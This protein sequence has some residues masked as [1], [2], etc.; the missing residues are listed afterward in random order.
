M[1]MR[2][3]AYL[4]V[5]RGV[6]PTTAA[7][8]ISTVQGWHA[9]RFGCRLAGGMQLGRVKALIKG[10][11]AAQGGVRPKKKRLGFKPRQLAQLMAELLGG[12]TALEANWRACFSVGFCGLLRGAELGLATGEAWAA[13]TCVTRADVSFRGKGG[14][15][16]AVLMTRPRKKGVHR[17]EQ[18]K[19]VPVLLTGGGKFLDPVR[20]LKELFARDPVPERLW[21]ST[22]LFRGSDGA[23][24]STAKVRGMVRTMVALGGVDPAL[25]GAHSLRIGGATA[26]LAAGVSALVIKAMGRWGSDVYEIYAHLSDVASRDFGGKVA[27]VD[28]EEVLG[29]YYS[30][31]L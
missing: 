13:D 2:F 28:Y 21:A 23:A 26:A 17:T 7:S 10:M 19:R 14:R 15:E 6:Q 29:A 8:Y 12:A 31:D 5:E 24:F 30:E 9:R 20:A 22:P 27:S 18:G 16:E 4:V 1:V 3:A 25:Y 11:L